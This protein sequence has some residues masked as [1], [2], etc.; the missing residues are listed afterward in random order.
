MNFHCAACFK[1]YTH[2]NFGSTPKNR[3]LELKPGLTS[4]A[5]AA[6]GFLVVRDSHYLCLR[7]VSHQNWP[8]LINRALY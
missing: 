7:T 1:K 5:W 2:K 3:P 4:A 6:M 8:L